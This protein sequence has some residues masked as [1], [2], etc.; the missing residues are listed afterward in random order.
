MTYDPDVRAEFDTPE[1]WGFHEESRK[2]EQ[3]RLDE[4]LAE[5]APPPV[6]KDY[7]GD[8][9]PAAPPLREGETGTPRVYQPGTLAELI[10]ERG[11]PQDDT[12]WAC[13]NVWKP[14]ALTLV[15]GT[16]QSFKSW[17]MFDLMYHAAKG[18]DWLDRSLTP[19]DAVVYVSNEK[20]FAA[21]YERLWLLFA[22]DMDLAG[23]VHIRHREDRIQ[24]GNENWERFVDWAHN[25]LMG[26]RI[27]L[28]LDTLTSLAPAGYDENNLKDVS[29]VLNHI[30]E[31][32]QG[33]RFDVMLVHHLNAMGERPRGHTALDGEV[34]GFVKFDRRGRDLDEVLVRFEPK[35]GLPSLQ[36][37]TFD[38]AKGM[39]KR[40]T[41]KSL[42]VGS[43]KTIV[44]WHQ[45]RNSGEGMTVKELKERYFNMYRYDQVERAV[46]QA[47]RELV[48][49]REKRISLLTNREANL[50]TV[51]SDEE[52][53]RILAHRRTV[54]D[55]EVENEARVS[56]E[57]RARDI[58]ERQAQ[59]ALD[60]LPED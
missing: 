20:S 13:S 4:L 18:T 54:E 15:V 36:T 60:S 55:I 26:S 38:S 19:Y 52:R 35:D 41:A 51:L 42:H 47:E 16:Q 50:I 49:K 56:A 34:D 23:K 59:A 14:G 17:S 5:D 10:I 28:I 8:P 9:V 27:L 44:Q 25:E 33:E 29:R 48:L 43:I 53:D 21:V 46:E 58:L 57:I 24:F 11:E 12:R 3:Q 45:E 37:F 40:A 2:R 31:L 6:L 7:K 32:Q 30:R 22:N 39:F 1:T